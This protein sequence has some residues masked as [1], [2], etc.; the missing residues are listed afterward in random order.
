MALLERDESL[1]TAR[2]YLDAAVG[3]N[4][5]LVF[6]AGEAGVGKTTFVEQVVREAADQAR[7]AHGSCD[8]SATPA[9]LGPLHEMLPDLPAHVWPAGAERHEVFTRL[10]AALAE[11]TTPYLLLVEDLHWADEA[12]LDLVRHLARR[13]HRLRA[14]VL[15]T[16]RVDEPATNPALRVLLGDVA[17]ASGT[18]RIDLSPLSLAAVRALVAETAASEPDLGPG[19]DAEELHRVTGGNPFF[20]TEVLDGHE[21]TVPDSVRA[22]VLARVAR[23]TTP[24]RAVLDAVA[25]AGP[26]AELGLVEHLDPGSADAVDEALLAG[27]LHLSGQA[28]MFRHELARLTVVDE[29]PALRLAALHRAIAEWLEQND[30]DAARI[31][32]HAEAG[33]LEEVACRYALVAAHE[34]AA[35]GSH[36]EAGDQYERALRHSTAVGRERAELLG[37]LSYERYVT[38]SIEEALAARRS[39]LELWE[40]IGDRI[41][42][43]DAQRAISRLSWFFGHGDVAEEYGV[44][45]YETLRGSGTVAEAMAASNRGQL[46]MLSLDLDGTREWSERALAIVENHPDGLEVESVRVHA[47]NN[48]GNM[49]IDSGDEKL[50][51]QLLG[52]SLRRSQEFD[53]HEH[54]ARAFANL[55]SCAVER[56]DHLRAGAVLGQGLEYCRERDLYAWSLYLQGFRSWSLLDRG[57]AQEAA[58]TAR[59]VL[60]HPRTTIVSRVLPLAVLARAYAR[61]GH[62]GCHEAVAE[63]VELAASTG[64]A[65]RVCVATAAACEVA[66]IAGDDDEVCRAAVEGWELV[67]QVQSPWVRGLVAPWLAD[68]EARAVADTLPPPHA[69]EAARDW[70]RAA[71]LWGELHSSFAEGLALARSGDRE[72]LSRAAEL[73]EAQGAVAAA[74]RARSIARKRGWATPRGRSRTTREHPLGLTGRQAE[75]LELLRDGLSNAAIAERLVVSPRTVEHHVAAILDKLNVSSRHDVRSVAEGT[76]E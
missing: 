57:R 2:D 46:C 17:G 41:E 71:E 19:P 61:L 32:Q 21:T 76:A 72:A 53:L 22:A 63:A 15:V 27:T 30:G 56:H 60:D 75:V 7:V 39:A 28:L 55:S 3:G 59:S 11:S 9:P 58:R 52:D 4:G 45:A 49:E 70:A 74:D 36:R 18:R 23:L 24:A 20:V 44:L 69:A 8:G 31:A 1:R 68:S 66:W 67:G 12:T 42:V 54:A 29:V 65:Q 13:A 43:G 10:S 38:S 64:E 50:G 47:L 37:N 62:D 33:G 26:R 34:A 6:V 5:R 16:Y 73:F 35:L 14:L 25:V 51:W 48:H 40:E